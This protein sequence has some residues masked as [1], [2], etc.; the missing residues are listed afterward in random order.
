MNR[1]LC[2]VPALSCCKKAIAL[3]LSISS[4]PA[5]FLFDLAVPGRTLSRKIKFDRINTGSFAAR[6]Y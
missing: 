4:F 6:D 5:F 2:Y 1:L 3:S